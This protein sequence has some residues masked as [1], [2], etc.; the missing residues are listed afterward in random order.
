MGNPKKVEETEG[1]NTPASENGGSTTVAVNSE[2][3]PSTAEVVILSTKK[4]HTF[5]TGPNSPVIT[6][7][8]V[9][10]PVGE[11]EAIVASAKAYNVTITSKEK[12][13]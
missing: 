3:N 6:P 12:E 10:V 9:E 4:G 11:A 5:S 2:V 8:G 7:A 13:A 1:Q